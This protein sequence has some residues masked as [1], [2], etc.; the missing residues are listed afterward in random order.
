MDY[1]GY[2]KA[3]HAL[4]RAYEEEFKLCTNLPPFSQLVRE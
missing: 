3:A 1:L 2:M 4:Q